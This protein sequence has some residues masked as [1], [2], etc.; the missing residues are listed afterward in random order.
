MSS[1]KAS[2]LTFLCQILNNTHLF[3]CL[4]IHQKSKTHIYSGYIVLC[5][6]VLASSVPLVGSPKHL[7]PHLTTRD[8]DRVSQQWILTTLVTG[9]LSASAPSQPLLGYLSHLVDP[10]SQPLPQDLSQ[11]VDPHSP[12]AGT[13]LS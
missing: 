11:L 3:Q 6:V 2:A 1:I 10:G 12:C 7:T 4:F 5:Y 9:P 8:R 13:S